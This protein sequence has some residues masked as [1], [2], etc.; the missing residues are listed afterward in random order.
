MC[1]DIGRETSFGAHGVDMKA[2][3]EGPHRV[4]N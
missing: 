2:F 1:F 3:G 4:G